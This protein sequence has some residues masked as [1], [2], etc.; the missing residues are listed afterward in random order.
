MAVVSVFFQSHGM[1]PFS[2]ELLNNFVK[3]IW[4]NLWSSNS[5]IGG[6]LSVPAD[7]VGLSVLKTAAEVMATSGN[8]TQSELLIKFSA[9][10]LCNV[11]S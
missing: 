8:H 6:I 10:I 1:D 7:F 9:G 4:R 5:T 11:S 3:G 2:I